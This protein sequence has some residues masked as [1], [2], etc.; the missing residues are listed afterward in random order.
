MGTSGSGDADRLRRIEQALTELSEAHGSGSATL[1]G[2]WLGRHGG[3]LR[4][5]GEGATIADAGTTADGVSAADQATAPGSPGAGSGDAGRAAASEG[6]GAFAATDG[7]AGP[8][9]GATSAAPRPDGLPGPG[10][11][12]RYFGDYLLEGEL[13]RG[14][15]GIVYRA[16]QISLGRPVALKM[17]REAAFARAEDLWRF[18]NEAEAVARLDHPNIVPV[19]EVGEHGQRE[20]FSMKL[21]DGARPRPAAAGPTTAT[22]GRSPRSSPRSPTASTMPTSA[23]SSTAISNPPMSSSTPRG[24][25]HVTDFGLAKRVEADRRPDPDRR[26][27]RHARL[28]GPRAGV[29]AP[30]GGDDRDGRLRRSAASSTP[31]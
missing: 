18:Q 30:L 7:G 27:A 14:G 8:R 26:R 6:T 1:P 4:S 28:H 29:G 16:T 11:A 23:A 13:G 21:V 22:C 12:V 20:Y 9:A 19:Y 31:C 17:L 25:P 5:P 15:M 2:P 3:L 24:E 10:D